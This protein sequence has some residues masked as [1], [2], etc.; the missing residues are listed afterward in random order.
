MTVPS[1]GPMDARILIVGEA[2]GVDEERLGEPFVGYS[3]QLLD[4]MLADAGISRAAC[5]ITNV[6]RERPPG[7]R[8]ELWLP[9]TKEAQHECTSLG[10]PTLRG[11]TVHPHIEKGYRLLIAELEVVQPTVI[12]GL[13]GTALWALTGKDSIAKWRGSTLEVDTDEMREG[14]RG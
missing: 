13:G 5:R 2:P 10:W 4:R 6:C 7:N 14:L 12:I 3:G 9:R 8:I 1:S 11:R